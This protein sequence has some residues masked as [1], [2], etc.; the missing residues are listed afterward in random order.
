MKLTTCL[1]FSALLCSLTVAQPA[2]K[3]V[4]PKRWVYV[5]NRLAS[6]K[7]LAD[8]RTIIE[9]AAAHGLNGMVLAGALVMLE[10]KST[11]DGHAVPPI[12][13]EKGE[14]MGHGAFLPLPV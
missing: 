2:E 4:Y 13:Q 11:L 6:D 5:S 10:R 9:T 7:D 8:I 1:L 3:K 12:R 14:W